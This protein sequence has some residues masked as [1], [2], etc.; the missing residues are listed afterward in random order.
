MIKKV[1]VTGGPV[2]A[3]LDSVKIITNK[4]KGG[5]MA[6]FAAELCRFTDIEVTYLCAKGSKE[7]S[8]H[9]VKNVVHHNGYEDYRDKVLEYAKTFDAI[10][11]GAAVC[12]LIPV[13]PWK[14]K[15]PS[16]DYKEGD[17]IDIPFTIA[18]RI[19]NMVKKV[20]PKITLIGYKLLSGVPEEELIRAA[21]EVLVGSKAD[22]VIAN[23]CESLD[24]KIAVCKDFSTH[25]LDACFARKAYGN[26]EMSIDSNFIHAMI[27]D[28]H[29][30]TECGMVSF[31][32]EEALAAVDALKVAQ[33]RIEKYKQYFTPNEAGYIFGSVAVRIQDGKNA[34][35]TTSR[36]KKDLNSFATVAHVDHKNKVVT[37]GIVKPTLN[38]PFLHHIFETHPEVNV[39]VHLHKKPEPFRGLQHGFACHVAPW[40]PPGTV[41]DSIRDAGFTIS[42]GGEDEGL[43]IENHGVFILDWYRRE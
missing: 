7:P 27:M 42:N 23:L 26:E 14:E 17:V 30:R 35:I 28:E 36:G 32:K 34:F 24:K 6:A 20:N 12:N 22:C 18:P 3:H 29:Y 1:L 41:R 25:N 2:H 40:A 16:H 9:M 43:Y 10:I 21:K 31:N 39:I 15:F 13:N 8:G 19:I 11:L 4:F 33:K 38:A 5:T 37:S